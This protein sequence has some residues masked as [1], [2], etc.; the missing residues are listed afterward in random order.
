MHT[1][2]PNIISILIAGS[3]NSA[4]TYS[5]YFNANIYNWS[6]ISKKEFMY[7]EGE[8]QIMA[9][10]ETGPWVTQHKLVRAGL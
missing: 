1:C 6:T 3:L 2:R 8:G 4:L 10:I 5:T 9:I 7:T